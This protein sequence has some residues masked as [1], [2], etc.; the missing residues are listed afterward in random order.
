MSK[1]VRETASY[2][3]PELTLG[4]LTSAFISLFVYDGGPSSLCGGDGRSFAH[5]SKRFSIFTQIDL[6]KWLNVSA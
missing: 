2:T 6:N 4:M 5:K 1:V 3:R